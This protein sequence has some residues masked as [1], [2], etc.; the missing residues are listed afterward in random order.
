MIFNS[1]FT[2]ILDQLSASTFTGSRSCIITIA[3]WRRRNSTSRSPAMKPYLPTLST[4]R[5]KKRSK[6]WEPWN[7]ILTKIIKIFLSEIIKIEQAK[8]ILSK[9]TRAKKER[10]RKEIEERKKERESVCVRECVRKCVLE[11]KRA[12]LCVGER[13]CEGECLCVWERERLSVWGRVKSLGC[14]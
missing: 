12:F 4:R 3:D 7:N 8:K 5:K 13:V 2:F 6:R 9:K 11:R 10:K 1:T 14:G